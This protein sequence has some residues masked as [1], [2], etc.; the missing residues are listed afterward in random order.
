MNITTNPQIKEDLILKVLNNF[1]AREILECKSFT[2]RLH[3]DPFASFGPILTIH[4][5]CVIRNLDEEYFTAI[6]YSKEIQKRFPII[7]NQIADK[8]PKIE[9]HQ[10]LKEIKKI[11]LNEI[12]SHIKEGDL[13]ENLLSIFPTLSTYVVP[14]NEIKNKKVFLLFFPYWYNPDYDY[15]F[16]LYLKEKG[17]SGST[18]I[19]LPMHG[20]SKL[21]YSL[22]SEKR[23][24]AILNF[25]DHGGSCYDWHWNEGQMK[26]ELESFGID[27]VPFISLLSLIPKNYYG[28]SGDGGFNYD[29]MNNIFQKILE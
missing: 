1:H 21:V 26:R 5:S 8:V 18:V 25:Y 29:D 15:S 12:I 13:I 11:D 2:V 22:T 16:L 27:P 24:D 3:P 19:R 28:D 6:E 17:F 10:Y 23:I 20:V 7:F 4:S 9:S 14:G